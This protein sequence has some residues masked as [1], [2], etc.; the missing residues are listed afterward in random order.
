MATFFFV[1]RCFGRGSPSLSF[2]T[3]SEPLDWHVTLVFCHGKHI[4]VK[5]KT[6][7]QKH[8]RKTYYRTKY[9]FLTL[10]VLKMCKYAINIISAP[11]FHFGTQGS[12]Y[13]KA[14]TV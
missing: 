4:I 11:L 9:T 13:I 6:T 1:C 12:R 10:K 7:L 8:V 14:K 2:V 3:V 5:T